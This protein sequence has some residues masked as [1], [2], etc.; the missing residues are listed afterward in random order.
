MNE[1]NF[2]IIIIGGGATGLGVAVDAVSRGYKT[3]LLE[4]HDFGKGTSSKS[5][6][7]VHGGIRYLANLDFALVKEGLEE[8]YYFLKN[9]PHLASKQT[10]LVP[11]YSLWDKFKY[12][13]GIKLY[14]FL[15]GELKIGKSKFLSKKETLRLKNAPDLKPEKLIGSAIYYDG[16]FDDTR[17]LISLLRTYMQLGGVAYNYHPVTEIIKNNQGKV[18]GVTVFNKLNSTTNKFMAKVVINATG[19]LTDSILDMDEP[20]QKHNHV[21]AAQ[22]THLVF[23]KEIFNSPHALVI[24][25]TLDN[26]ILFVLPWHNKIIVGTTDIAVQPTEI[27][28]KPS[29]DEVDFILDTLNQYSKN[30]VSYSDI[31]SKFAGLRP[32]VKP[33]HKTN[34]AKIS[35]KHEILLSDSNLIS[36]VG[37]KWTIYRLMG[38]D[39]IDFLIKHKMLKDKGPSVTKELKIFGYTQEKISYPL[40]MYGTDYVKIIQIQKDT[41][42]FDK[43]HPSLPYYQA[44]IIYHIRYEMAHTLEDVLARRI[45]ALFLD[46][47][48]TLECAELTASIMAKELG[49]NQEWIDKQLEAFYLICKGYLP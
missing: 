11:F 2:D 26:R 30:K 27:D 44:E 18:N 9:S 1:D 13:I 33:A 43:L 14:D 46:A 22:G 38:S 8:R 41:G 32:L 21:T 48:A 24:P 12:Y 20:Q 45:R 7:L 37:G 35:R 39:T 25:K 28:P 23:N 49:E 19:T 17:L 16:Q 31:K 42:N 47:K 10:Y 15:S 34:S 36:I 40:S 5:T 29:R 6:K 4:A 3:L